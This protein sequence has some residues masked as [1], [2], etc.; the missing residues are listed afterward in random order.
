MTGSS[1]TGADVRLTV[2]GAEAG[3][4]DE[5]GTA[6]ERE[7]TFCGGAGA[8]TDGGGSNDAPHIPQ[9][10]FPSEFSLPQREQRTTKVL[11]YSLRYLGGSMQGNANEGVQKMTG[12]GR[13]ERLNATFGRHSHGA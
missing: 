5:T 13:D 8:A 3:V 7:A 9:K 11:M 10:R 1:E 4:G 2:G 12:L 6:E